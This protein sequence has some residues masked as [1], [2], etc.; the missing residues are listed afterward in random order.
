MPFSDLDLARR[1]EQ[2][3]GCGNVAFVEARSR[4]EP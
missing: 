3:E 2:A 4:V 1:L